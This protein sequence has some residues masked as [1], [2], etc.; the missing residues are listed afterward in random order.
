MNMHNERD[1]S[2]AQV[3][4]RDLDVDVR[5]PD[6][7]IVHVHIKEIKRYFSMEQTWLAIPHAREQCRNPWEVLSP[8]PIEPMYTP[9]SS[10]PPTDD[11]GS[12]TDSDVDPSADGVYI[13]L[14]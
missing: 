12:I 7:P 9:N 10:L 1:V 4:K 14:R 5:Y 3:L 6:A 11:E 13:Y 2:L 8:Q